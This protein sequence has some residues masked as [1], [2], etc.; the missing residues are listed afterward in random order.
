M[1]SATLPQ[2]IADGHLCI[3]IR[4]SGT[5]AHKNRGVGMSFFDDQDPFGTAVNP[6]VAVRWRCRRCCPS[7]LSRRV[8]PL[9]LRH[10]H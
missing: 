4:G 2:N 9:V 10:A 1:Q 6:F 8:A 5:V 3:W 7:R